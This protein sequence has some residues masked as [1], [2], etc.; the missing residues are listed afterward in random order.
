M[1]SVRQKCYSAGRFHDIGKA[2]A[3][4]VKSFEV[5]LLNT[6]LGI[7]H[8][9]VWR[10]RAF[11]WQNRRDGIDAVN[12]M[13]EVCIRIQ[14]YSYLHLKKSIFE[15]QITAFSFR[16]KLLQIHFGPINSMLDKI[17]RGKNLILPSPF[18]SLSDS[19]HFLLHA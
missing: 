8:A 19:L 18:S 16:Q 11:F 7:S 3:K 13:V 15:N 4:N 9:D 6:G 2:K 12:N 14:M 1:F 5:S 10:T 17:W